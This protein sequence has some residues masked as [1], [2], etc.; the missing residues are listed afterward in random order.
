MVPVRLVFAEPTTLA[1]DTPV[2][3]DVDAEER[4]GVVFVPPEAVVGTGASAV[5]Y[6]AAG[7]QAQRRSVTIGIADDERVEITSGVGAGDLVITRGHTNLPDGA[8]ISVEVQRP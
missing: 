5:V 1:V 6:V 7:S 3:V 2:Q 4:A 8:A